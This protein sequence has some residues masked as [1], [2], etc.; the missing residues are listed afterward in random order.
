MLVTVQLP[1]RPFTWQVSAS[2]PSSWLS[3]EDLLWTES[4]QSLCQIPT[5]TATGHG[6]RARGWELRV[7]CECKCECDA[8]T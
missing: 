1:A 2:E 4:C 7:E 6:P 8:L 5:A 3:D